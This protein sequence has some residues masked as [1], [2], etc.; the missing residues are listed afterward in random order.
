MAFT[1]R[2]ATPQDLPQMLQIVEE[3]RE[4][5]RL[6]GVD[7]WQKGDP[8]K[9]GLE[10]DIEAGE[11]WVLEQNGSIVATMALA[12]GEEED[13]RRLLRGAWAL[14]EP[15]IS[16]HRFAVSQSLRHTG[17]SA[18]LLWEIENACKAREIFYIRV[19]TH[20]Q[21]RPMRRFLEKGGFT[22]RGDLA[23]QSGAEK[24]ALRV[25]YDKQLPKSNT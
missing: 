5:L 20:H 18:R 15:Y 14:N 6:Q 24:G 7:Q 4:F 21:N 8:N 13:Y 17:L 12:T 3:G 2:Q 19:D 1:F 10:K 22:C 23:L 11:A 16:L 9:A 25:A